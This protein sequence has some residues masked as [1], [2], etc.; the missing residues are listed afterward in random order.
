M[1]NIMLVEDEP[2]FAAT[3]KNLIQ[4]NPCYVVTDIADHA[5]G[6]IDAVARRRP[7]LA[8][9]D[10]Q[11]AH[12]STGFTVAA[13]LRDL[14]IPCLFTSGKVPSFPMPDL[15]IGCLVK[16]FR[17]EDLVRSLRIV[18]D[19]VRGRERWRRDQP[20]RLW[21]YEKPPE[22]DPSRVHALAADFPDERGGWRRRLGALSPLRRRHG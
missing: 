3:L 5:A 10:L 22:R 19:L 1:F 7:D 11:L 14:G 16:P 18:E 13:K 6:A 8:L 15:A 9:V 21:L 2:L 17:E 4:L 12:G 20:E